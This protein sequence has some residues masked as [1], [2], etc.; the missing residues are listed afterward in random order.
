MRM[1]D[2]EYWKS[3][4]GNCANCSQDVK[5]F[6]LLFLLVVTSKLIQIGLNC[7]FI[8]LDSLRILVI[9]EINK[10]LERPPCVNQPRRST[11]SMQIRQ[12]DLCCWPRTSHACSLRRNAAGLACKQAHISVLPDSGILTDA[13]SAAWSVCTT[14]SRWKRRVACSVPQ[15]PPARPRPP[16]RRSVASEYISG[17]YDPEW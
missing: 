15:G 12:V 1:S 6:F 10:F 11:S 4:N 14:R 16:A 3:N 2:S 17:G 5:C 7:K 8:R 9:S 13:Y